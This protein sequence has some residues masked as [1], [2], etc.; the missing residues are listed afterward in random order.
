MKYP[1]G[2]VFVEMKQSVR[3]FHLGIRD[4]TRLRTACGMLMSSSSEQPLQE[5]PVPFEGLACCGG[6]LNSSS[7]F[8]RAHFGGAPLGFKKKSRSVASRPDDEMMSLF[9]ENKNADTPRRPGHLF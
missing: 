9:S 4:G 3:C 6:C 7:K 5:G 8:S 2:L 1:A